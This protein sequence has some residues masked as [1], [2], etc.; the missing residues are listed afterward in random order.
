[1]HHVFPTSSEGV[2]LNDC[3]ISEL[4]S[5]LLMKT[6]GKNGRDTA[7]IDALDYMC[8]RLPTSLQWLKRSRASHD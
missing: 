1:M 2:K 5:R 3:Q 4:G 6:I 7:S 8:H